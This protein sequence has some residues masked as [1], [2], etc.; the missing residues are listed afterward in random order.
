MVAPVPMDAPFPQPPA[1]H[2]H[3]APV[4]NVP[5]LTLILVFDP[6]QIGE[7]IALAP[8]G[9]EEGIFTVTVTVA[10]VVFPQSPS[11]LTKYVV[12]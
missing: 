10:H 9:L 3:D 11:A 6:M 4:P 1:Y 12:V 7:D 8:D 5:P 2:F